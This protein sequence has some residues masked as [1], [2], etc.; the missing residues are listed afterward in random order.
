MN[1]HSPLPDFS[2]VDPT[3]ADESRLIIRGGPLDS[4]ANAILTGKLISTPA[5][6]PALTFRRFT[7]TATIPAYAT[8]GAAGMDLHADLGD[9]EGQITLAPGER[10]VVKTGIGMALPVSLEGQVRPRSGLAAKHGITVLNAPGTIDSDYRGDIGVILYNASHQQFVVRH[11]DRIAQFVIA[12][13][14][15]VRLEEVDALDATERGEGGFGSTGMRAEGDASLLGHP[16]TR[17]FHGG[18]R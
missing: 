14:V 4:S 2:F 12:P 17:Q 11:G 5:V 1:A 8:Q 13:V 7:E 3:P 15:Q 16:L 9:V 18:R 10:R 6:P